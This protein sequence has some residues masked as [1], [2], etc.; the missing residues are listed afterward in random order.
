[1]TTTLPKT[2]YNE[3]T[4]PTTCARKI[5]EPL[6]LKRLP[7]PCPFGVFDVYDA[8]IASSRFLSG[9]DVVGLLPSLAG[10]QSLWTLSHL[11]G[12][13]WIHLYT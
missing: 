13:C 9:A 1:M 6:P 10:R 7:I 8:T 12:P 4:A 11:E 5:R 3:E 2:A